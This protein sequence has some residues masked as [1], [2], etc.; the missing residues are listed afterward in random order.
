M[1][2]HRIDR[3]EELFSDLDV[4]LALGDQGQHLPFPGTQGFEGRSPL[5]AAAEQFLQAFVD[6]NPATTHRL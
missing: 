2:F 4:A 6:I 5:M 3:H 1:C